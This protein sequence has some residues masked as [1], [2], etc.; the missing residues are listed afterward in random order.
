[1]HYF[2]LQ[3]KIILTINFQ[4]CVVKKTRIILNRISGKGH[5]H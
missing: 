1:M 5:K 3:P 4:F 2:N